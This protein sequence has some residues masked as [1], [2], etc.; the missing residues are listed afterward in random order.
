MSNTLW[1]HFLKAIQKVI[2]LSNI[3]TIYQK[4]VLQT[5]FL[6]ITNRDEFQR[7]KALNFVKE[8]VFS[9][10]EILYNDAEAEQ[11]FADN[12]HKVITSN[13][14]GI[15]IKFKLSAADLNIFLDILAGMK[16]FKA[17]KSLQ[18]VETLADLALPV[19]FRASQKTCYFE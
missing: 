11:F 16:S 4:G 10:R 1:N 6:Q 5:L 13:A 7:E 8:K 18:L 15:T 12:F 14:L 19:T 3:R 9:L 17:E 2:T